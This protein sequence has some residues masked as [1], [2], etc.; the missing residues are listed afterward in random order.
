M[1]GRT[2]T[3]NGL[4]ERVVVEV[5]RGQKVDC[6]PVGMR[7]FDL[8]AVDDDDQGSRAIRA[9]LL[10]E[11]CTR[12]G[13]VDPR[14]GVWIRGAHIVGRVY[15]DWS[16]VRVPLHFEVCRFKRG[17]NLYA[18]HVRSV[19]FE[20]CEIG[21]VEATELQSEHSLMFLSSCLKSVLVKDAR[22]RG[23]VRL[24]GST[25]TNPNGHAFVG[26]RLSSGAA[27]F[28]KATVT[29]EL[30]LAGANIGSLDLGGAEL[31]NAEG[32]AFVGDAMSVTAGASF[33]NATV[34]GEL[35]M[36]GAK[37]GALTL[38]DAILDNGRGNAFDGDAMSVTAGASFSNATVKGELRLRGA[39]VGRLILDGGVLDNGRGNAF[40]GDAMSVTAGASFA[41]AT[42]KGELRLAGAQIDGGL[43]LD[44]VDLSN[45]G[46][47][48][49]DGDSFS[50]RGNVY[51]G[52][53]RVTGELRLGGAQISGRLGLYRARL[54]NIGGKAFVGDGLSATGDVRFDHALV[55]GE[56]RLVGA[57]ISG[58]LGLYRARLYNIG[59][60][61]FVGDGLSAT[62]DVRFGDAS[63]AGELRMVRARV[64]ATL[65]LQTRGQIEGG[66]HLTAA[67]VG[68]LADSPSSWPKPKQLFLDGFSY[69]LT[70][71][72]GN[73][74][75]NRLKWI[76][77]NHDFSPGVYDQLAGVYRRAGQDRDARKVAIAREDDRRDD[78]QL[79]RASYL[80]NCFLSFTV[81]HGYQPW[82]A[83]L[84][85]AAA[86][87]VSTLAFSWGPAAKKAMAPQKP[88]AP[89]NAQECTRNYE[90]FQPLS[91]SLDV[92]LPVVD[93]NQQSYWLPNADRSWG[94]WYRW[95]TWALILIGWLLTTAVVAAL[96]TLWRA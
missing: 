56:L 85:L 49:F 12:R 51:F 96:S 70:G 90:C 16:D 44:H 58:E 20:S 42:V 59:G 63:V 82:R 61:A 77:R 19:H 1:A 87:F 26:D 14:V 91:Y 43:D 81:K 39:K 2:E 84:F 47:N 65:D 35:G 79:S 24:R 89:V 17:L 55:T 28:N 88:N 22:I 52:D 40:V 53:A 8:G 62:G 83:V 31:D 32:N 72:E 11:L 15:L 94:S 71:A 29:G 27:D 92:L 50:S 18:A 41:K 75:E 80:W 7:T 66:L 46:R 86:V 60:K 68:N 76:R 9:E 64:A 33:S 5:G 36:R 73:S 57:Q 34:K 30:F 69:G 23:S 54:Y 95:L 38:D 21:S 13:A 78:G 74:V 67:S 10:V 3:Q 93:L 6:A 48:A 37:V 25:L 4:E 45:P